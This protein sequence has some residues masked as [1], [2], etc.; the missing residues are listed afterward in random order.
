MKPKSFSSLTSRISATHG[1]APLI[2]ACFLTLTAAAT[3]APFTAGNVTVYRVGSGTG[4]LVNTGN[5][6]FIDEYTPAGSLVQS[7]PLPTTVVGANKRLIAS[8]T[9]TSEGLLTRS[10]DGQFLIATGYDATTPVTGLTGSAAATVNR[11]IGRVNAAGAV[12]TTTALTD[13][14]TGNNVRGA[15]ST[16][17]TDF[18][19]AGG[20]GGIRHTTLG[21]TTS[22]QLSTTVTNLRQPGILNGQLLVSTGSGTAVRIGTVGS[23]LPTTSGQTISNL[24]GIPATSGS[25]YAFFF[26]D[27]DSGAPGFDTLYV[28]DD[29]AAALTK[30]SL[31][32]GSWTSNGTVGVDAD[33]YRGLTGTVSGSNVTLFASRK[34]GSGATGGGE[35]VSLVD[36]SGYNGAFT[37]TPTLLATAA[38]NTAF[39]GI[40]LAPVSATPPAGTVSIS[41]AS[42]NEGNGGT[43]ILSLTV[44]RTDTTAAFTVNY[45]VTG[46]TATSGSDYEAVIPGTLTFTAG[47]AASQNIDIVV[48]GDTTIESN[49]TIALTLSGIVDAVGVTTLGTVTA[50]GTISND[51]SVASSFPA[52][53]A[54]TATFKGSIALTG[55]EIPAFDPVSKRAFTSTSA[56]IQIVDLTDPAL[57]TLAGNIVPSSLGVSGLTSDDV[58]SIAIRKGAG[59]NPSVLAAAIISSPKSNAGYVIFLNAATGV[60]L[61]STP[62]GAVPDHIAFTPDGTKLLVANEGELDGAAVDISADTVPGTVSIIDISSGVASPV[63]TTADFTSYDAPATITALKDSGVRIFQG[64]KPSTDFEPEYF[65]ISADGTT[66]MVTLQEANA[67]AVLDIATATFTSVVPLGKKNFSAGRH[68]FSDRDGAGAT[69]L[70]NPTTGN[71]VFGLYMPDAISSYNSAGQTYYITANEGDDRNDFLNPDESTTVG[72]AGYV[73]DPTVFPNA[74]TLKDPANLGRLTVSNAPGLRGDTDNDG[75]IDEILSYGG[76]SFT[77]LDSAG[78]IIFDSGD[79][80]ENIVAS[81][82]FANFDDGRSD[83]KGPEPEGVTI[84]VIGGRTYAFVGL[85]RSHMV[86]AFDVTNPL[87]VTFSGGFRKTAD[88]NPEGLVVVSAEDSP[89][90]KPLLLVANEVSN[91]LTIHE[92]TNDPFATW[93]GYNGYTS[94]GIDT[95]TDGDGLTDRVEFFFNQNPNSASDFGNLPL[96]VPNG[97]ALELDFAINNLSGLPGNLEVS[98]DLASWTNALLGVDYTVASSVATGD[99]TAFTYAL[100]GTGPSAPGVSPTYPA[101]NN[102]DPAGASLGGVRIVNEGLVGVGRLSGNDIDQFGETQ[103]AASGLFITDWRLEAGQLKGTFNVLPDRGYNSGTTFSNYAARLHRVT[104]DF[105]P[106]Y[107]A[108]PVAQGQIA[109][110]YVSS[111]RFTYQDGATMKFTTGL[112]VAATGSLF[113]Q[114]VGVVTAANGLG[115]AQES[116]LSFDAEAVHLF[117]DGSGFVSDEY[118]TYIARFNAAKQITGITQLPESAR[119]HSPFG[120]L[121]FKSTITPANGRRQN[122]GLEGMSVTPDGTRLFAVMQSALVQDTNGANQ[123]TRNH[124]RLFVYDVAGANRETPVLIGQYV[125]KLPQF[126]STGSGAVNRT[127][128]QSEIVALNGT[129]FLMLPRDGN[130]LGTGTTAPIVFKSVQL[131][132]FASATNI[133]G[134]YDAEGAAVS[135][136]GVLADGVKAA[137]SAEIINM[138]EPTDLAKFKLNANTNPS[139]SD[140]LNEKM[141]G[142]ALVPDLSTPQENDFFLFLAN[143]NDFQSSDVKMLNA[144]GVFMTGPNGEPINGQSNAGI[145]NDAMFYAYRITIDAGGRKFFRFGIK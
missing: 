20:A 48:N 144:A 69:N 70:V 12:D 4:S 141:E 26:A 97:G 114:S 55:A 25:P 140:T 111:T 62:V 47:G 100:P 133:L 24:P 8:G 99:E 135:P 115:G 49:E 124:T 30:Y 35:I 105:T 5:E 44:T 94:T 27:L 61:G 14:A 57:P 96:L 18:W 101:S 132:D 92:I 2:A 64:G 6:V 59:A 109:P 83:N 28:A 121:N 116:L 90:G 40:A 84:A 53:G 38:T 66:A 108:V 50:N 106:Y 65:A 79:M 138:L 10:A 34:G 112:D 29:T 118:G 15:A 54:L 68:D 76:R 129:S 56:G 23:G 1:Q 31:V 72:N 102:S 13:A 143:D 77:I 16:D 91:T 89:T 19:I 17:G 42:I 93:L 103:G 33:D 21:G 3:A 71:P 136:A 137:A 32:G 86:L 41:G 125:V 113:G 142:M 60:L 82:F 127:A 37:G 22:T 74:A 11:V 130:G 120:T 95:D 36:A 80:I 52:T 123:Q 104:F 81:Q 39:R 131:V 46:G 58:S 110:T 139:N 43:S 75:D 107:G 85:E 51:D 117:D 73:L 134:T 145:T 7:I 128:A 119:P 63:V 78:A 98:N 88:R 122:Q 126:H 9:S 87:A 45:A 67:V